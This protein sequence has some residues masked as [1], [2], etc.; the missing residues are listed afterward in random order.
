MGDRGAEVPDDAL[1]S[2]VVSVVCV[3]LVVA[4]MGPAVPVQRPAEVGPAAT[5]ETPP[6]AI[7]PDQGEPT[8]PTAVPESA[9][10]VVVEPPP[11]ADPELAPPEVAETD[12]APL[13]VAVEP[14]CELEPDGCLAPED[15]AFD[16]TFVGEDDTAERNR[17]ITRA[18]TMLAAG[19]L[20]G[21]ASVLL[22]IAAGVEASKPACKFG[23][24]TCD[25]G[26]R[27]GVAAG[28]GV[29]GAIAGLG[30]AALIT[31]GVRRLR[32]LKVGV[33]GDEQSASVTLRGRF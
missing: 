11:V 27:K 8:P 14:D 20:S 33:M 9:D 6:D 29:T 13:P 5:S 17:E 25:S 31:V 12:P 18:R 23:L 7:V 26:P 28:L 24:E 2:S 19:G 22:L 3:A 16:I 15:D 32:R 21:V 1:V 10:P 4:Q 30:A